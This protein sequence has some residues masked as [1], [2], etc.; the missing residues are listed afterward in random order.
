MLNNSIVFR[1]EKGFLCAVR[2]NNNSYDDAHNIACNRLYC[3]NVTQCHDYS[4]IYFGFG[5]DKNGNR[6]NTWWLT[7]DEKSKYV[8]VYVFREKI[9]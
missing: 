5:H 9:E 7:N 4:H 8:P 1:D 6:V 3:E 2:K